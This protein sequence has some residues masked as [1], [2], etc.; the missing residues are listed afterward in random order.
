MNKLNYRRAFFI[1]IILIT[2]GVVLNTLIKENV[3]AIGTVF[4]AVGGLF[5]I[6][7]MAKKKSQEQNNSAKNENKI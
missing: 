3:T 7:S 2:V 6:I 1:S 4:I 5:F